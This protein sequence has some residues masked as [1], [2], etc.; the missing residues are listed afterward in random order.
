MVSMHSLTKYR[1]LLENLLVPLSPRKQQRRASRC[2]QVCSNPPL[3][4]AA[5]P[6]AMIPNSITPVMAIANLAGVFNTHVF[7]RKLRHGRAPSF[8]LL[9]P[10]GGGG[11]GGG[12]VTVAGEES[13]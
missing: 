8:I 3:R 13:K 9:F 7:S 1:W 4:A 10:V 2:A 6:S 11:E 5:N 12:G